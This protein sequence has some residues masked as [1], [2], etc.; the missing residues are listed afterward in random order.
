[1]AEIDAI[2]EIGGLE[3][4]PDRGEE[5]RE[6]GQVKHAAMKQEE[7]HRALV[8]EMTDVAIA[9]PAAAWSGT[10]TGAGSTGRRGSHRRRP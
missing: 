2:V 9:A 6:M 7:R 3:R 5:E 4:E 8:G 10:T 1:M